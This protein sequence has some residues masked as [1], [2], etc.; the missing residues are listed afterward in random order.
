MWRPGIGIEKN[1]K[2]WNRDTVMRNEYLRNIDEI[3]CIR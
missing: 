2:K 3:V 1:P